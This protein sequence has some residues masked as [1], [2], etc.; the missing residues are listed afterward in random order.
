[1]A[2][3]KPFIGTKEIAF[4]LAKKDSD[5]FDEDKILAYRGDR[6]SRK[7]ME[8][9]L[10]FMDGDQVWLPYSQDIFQMQQYETFCQETSG[11]HFLQY[12]FSVAKQR[13]KEI[14]R[15]PITT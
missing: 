10:Q 15:Q 12:T 1:V 11:L 4:E 8:F 14:N 7:T 13:I 2:R 5:Q 6:N 9:L 3:L